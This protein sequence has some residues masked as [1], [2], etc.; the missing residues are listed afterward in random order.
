M[1]YF[2]IAFVALLVALLAGCNRS[3]QTG[4]LPLAPIDS[5]DIPGIKLPAGFHIQYYAQD[6]YGAR[7]MTLS[8]NGVLYVGTRGQGCVYAVLDTNQDHR[9][10]R[11]IVIANNLESPNGVVWHNGSLYVAEISRIW[12]YDDI[13]NRLDAPPTPVLI[14]DQL[15]TDGH[16]GWKFIAFG[17]DNKLYVP[18]GAPCNICLKDDERYASILRMNPDGS[19]IEVYAHGIRNTVGFAW[20]PDTK[21]LWFTDNGRDWG[22]NDY[23]PEELN[24]APTAG[25]HFGF[26]FCFG[27]GIKDPEFGKPEGCD[28]YQPAAAEMP[29]HVAPLGMLFYTGQMFPA[30]YR[31]RVLICEHGSWNRT[32]PMGYRVS[33]L[34]VNGREATGYTQLADGWLKGGDKTGRPVDLEQLPD[35]SVLVSDDHAGAI[36]RISYK[37][38]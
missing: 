14:T 24:C 3:P 11:V 12:R 25:L 15:P 5:N 36:Y 13:D 8:P 16:H 37:T 18:V 31:N 23:P 35:G 1:M 29:A 27:K 21:E 34:T 6:I 2:P 10:D 28:A 7:S 9:A 17:P 4:D 33:M 20:H 19:D 22:G 32:P 30:E 38:P 26:P